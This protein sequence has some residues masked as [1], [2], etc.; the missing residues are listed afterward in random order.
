MYWPQINVA[1]PREK[2]STSV[3]LISEEE[4]TILS[5]HY[6]PGLLYT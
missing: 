1:S 5:A 6:E 2:F 4:T 3:S